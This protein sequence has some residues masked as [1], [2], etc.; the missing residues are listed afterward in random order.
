MHTSTRALATL[1]LSGFL[2]SYGLAQQSDSLRLDKGTYG[3]SGSLLCSRTGSTSSDQVITNV[4]AACTYLRFITSRLAFGGRVAYMYLRT[5]SG[6]QYSETTSFGIGPDLRYYA[7]RYPVPVFLGLDV[8]I[9]SGTSTVMGTTHA[10]SGNSYATLSLGSDF[11]ITPTF[12]LEPFV[13]Y[14]I[15]F[16]GASTSQSNTVALGLSLAHYIFS[17]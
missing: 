11:F 6:D 14:Q 9:T 5:S 2:T 15:G 4:T 3:L 16:S 1:M 13:Q 8:F 17:E 7:I 12:A 10:Q